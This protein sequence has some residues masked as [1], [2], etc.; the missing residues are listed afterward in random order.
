MIHMYLLRSFFFLMFNEPSPRYVGFVPS[1]V[2]FTF[3][4]RLCLQRDSE[5]GRKTV[6]NEN[7]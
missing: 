3:V 2:L 5:L 1:S 7:V 4:Y 6:D